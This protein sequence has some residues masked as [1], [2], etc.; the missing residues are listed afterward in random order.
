MT[1]RPAALTPPL[2]P[3]PVWFVGGEMAISLPSRGVQRGT[4]RVGDRKHVNKRCMVL[5]KWGPNYGEAC[6]GVKPLTTPAERPRNPH[7]VPAL[8][9]STRHRRA[10]P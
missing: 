9:Q 8:F 7:Q 2:V 4:N 10:N 5:G 3:L 1:L 6:A